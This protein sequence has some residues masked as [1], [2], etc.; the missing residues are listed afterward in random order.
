MTVRGIPAQQLP[1]NQLDDAVTIDETTLASNP[2]SGKTEETKTPKKA[3][4]SSGRKKSSGSK[5]DPPSNA[6]SQ[7]QEQ[8]PTNSDAGAEPKNDDKS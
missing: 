8:E 6:T 4:S 1:E 2:L 7:P 3:S 5:D